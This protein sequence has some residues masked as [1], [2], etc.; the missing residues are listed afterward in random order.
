MQSSD[1]QQK[2]KTTE[3]YVW[4]LYN[5][6]VMPEEKD[7]RPYLYAIYKTLT[8]AIKEKKYLWE[9]QKTHAPD[10][11]SPGHRSRVFILRK[12]LHD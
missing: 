11:R 10:R 4:L 1:I 6:N 9:W 7:D 2:N 3:E 5:Y 8:G 12:K